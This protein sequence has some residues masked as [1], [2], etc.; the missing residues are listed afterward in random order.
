MARRAAATA[1]R[2]VGI[3]IIP[4]VRLRRVPQQR[5]NCARKGQSA[6]SARVAAPSVRMNG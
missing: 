2:A 4:H 3:I 6:Q 1:R 5:V